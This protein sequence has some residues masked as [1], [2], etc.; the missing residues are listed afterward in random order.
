VANRT[1]ALIGAL[2]LLAF[3]RE[4][5]AQFGWV[6]RLLGKKSPPPAQTAPQLPNAPAVSPGST[7]TP[8][9]I[10]VAPRGP[11]PAESAAAAAQ[12]EQKAEKERNLDYGRTLDQKEK[13]MDNA[14]ERLSFWEGMKLNYGFDAETHQRY[15]AARRDLEQLKQE[16]SVRKAADKKSLDL[17]A[18]LERAQRSLNMRS[19]SDVESITDDILSTDPSNQRALALRD[20]ARAYQKAKRLKIALFAA[21]GAAIA[22]FLVLGTLAKKVF[23]KENA[24]GAE[25]SG[26]AK[27]NAAASRGAAYI[28][29]IDGVGRGKLVA[30]KN[31]VFRIGAAAGSDEED[32]NDLVISDTLKAVSRFHCSILRKG[33]DYFLI[34]SSLNG[35]RLNDRVLDRGENHRLRDGDEFSVADVA[36]LKFVKT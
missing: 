22:L 10:Q 2:A 33:R 24:A 27:P 36:R 5:E 13:T 28:K 30:I 23:K 9:P 18:K 15:E 32:R 26:A 29:I 17:N 34:D 3:P 8:T 11:T 4:A 31:D 7:L 35:T 16:D 12:A 21:A 6:K 20:Q 19:I 14:K 25:A 1:I